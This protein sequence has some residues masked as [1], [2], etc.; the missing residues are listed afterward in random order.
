MGTKKYILIGLAVVV[1]IGLVFL[2]TVLLKKKPVEWTREN[3]MFPVGSPPVVLETPG[4]SNVKLLIDA[5]DF[6]LS[7][8]NKLDPEKSFNFGPDRFTARQLKESLE[9][10][11][12]KLWEYGLTDR[13]FQYVR[14]HYTFYKSA[15]DEVLFTGYYEALLKGSMK[16]SK[17]YRYPLYKTP[18]DLIRIDLSRY[19]F[20]ERYK[21]LPKVLRGRLSKENRVVP[22]YSRYEIDSR[23]KLAEKGLEMVWIDNPIDIFFLQIQGSGIV[24][25]DTG[26]NM[27]VNYADSNGHAYRAIGRLMV[28][29]GLLT[30]ENASMQSIRAYLESHPEEMEEIFNYNPSYVFFREVEEGPIGC[31]GVP[32]TAFRSI[33]TDR[34]LFP[35]G[36]LCYIETELPEFDEEHQIKGWKPYRGFV[37]NQDTGGAIRS[38]R[39]VDLFTG[40]GEAS[41][42]VAGHMKRK[43]MFYFLIKKHLTPLPPTPLKTEEG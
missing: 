34:G 15:A 16:K 24:Q 37:L 26:E 22:Y 41:E 11:K 19:Y 36:G 14:A 27:R 9:D 23:Q 20:Y 40:F 32:V 35:G 25:L 3:A 43:G 12:R 1:V 39:R 21:G 18:E 29:R 30:L 38:P 31:L 13:F 28:D 7:Y 33:A 5:I 8:F 2:L 17:T 10:F 42:L 4:V 6:S